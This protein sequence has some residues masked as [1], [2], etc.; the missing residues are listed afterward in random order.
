MS[1]K[2]G[3]V[4]TF[5]LPGGWLAPLPSRQLRHCLQHSKTLEK[6]ENKK[7]FELNVQFV[8]IFTRFY[9]ILKIH[10]IC[11]AL[12]TLLT[13]SLNIHDH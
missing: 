11:N 8:R 13:Q 6:Q 4:F 3:P 10:K 5:T 2:G 7:L 12:T 1:T 9:N